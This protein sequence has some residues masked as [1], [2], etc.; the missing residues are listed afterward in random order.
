MLAVRALSYLLSPDQDFAQNEALLDALKIDRSGYDTSSPDAYMV[1]MLSDKNLVAR[2]IALRSLYREDIPGAYDDRKITIATISEPVKN[3]LL[4]IAANDDYFDIGN[5]PNPD[6][7]TTGRGLP[8]FIAP[9]RNQAIQILNANGIDIKLDED[10]LIYDALAWIGRL[11][12]ERKR[13]E[14]RDA[15]FRRLIGLEAIHP[16]MMY[17]RQRAKAVFEEAKKGNIGGYHRHWQSEIMLDFFKFLAEAT[18]EM[19]KK[20]LEEFALETAAQKA[21]E[22]PEPSTTAQTTPEMATPPQPAATPSETPDAKAMKTSDWVWLMGLAVVL[23]AGFGYFLYREWK[24][25]TSVHD[26][27]KKTDPME[28]RPSSRTDNQ[29]RK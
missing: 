1:S 4:D 5:R 6:P 29:R 17:A 23:L 20:A 13:D 11:Y 21:A 7:M 24:W 15:I 19:W 10:K 27:E 12:I 3:A 8:Y 26:G 28:S 2:D 18:P 16:A 9:F 14:D 25:G 22:T